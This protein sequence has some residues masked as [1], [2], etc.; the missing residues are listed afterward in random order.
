MSAADRSPR[1]VAATGS[2]GKLREIARILPDFEI[3]PLSGFPDVVFPEEGDDYASNA[4]TKAMVVAHST[5]LPSLA[6][7]SGLEVEALGGRPGV[8]SARYGGSTLTD[9]DRCRLLLDELQDRPRPWRARFVC[10]AACASPDGR[11]WSAVGE[12][13]GEIA[14]MASGAGGFG[15]DPI[16]VP[17]GALRTWAELDDANKDRVS[18]RGCAFRS[19]AQRLVADGLV[20]APRR[21][22]R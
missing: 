1:F 2:A 5:G 14:G 16:F 22:G 3:V 13:E 7:D 9:A 19:L 18:H 15:Y 21:R 12:C 6:D 17:R 10:W 20:Q 4:R 11:R 8:R